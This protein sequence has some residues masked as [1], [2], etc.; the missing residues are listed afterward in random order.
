MCRKFND[1]DEAVGRGNRRGVVRLAMTK[2]GGAPFGIQ[3]LNLEEKRVSVQKFENIG[4]RR[5]QLVRESW[6]RD[7]FQ[8]FQGSD[9]PC[10]RIA[11]NFAATRTSPLFCFVGQ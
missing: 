5:H 9:V 10:K 3:V 8:L 2:F 1:E 4:G 7:G 11:E 6:K